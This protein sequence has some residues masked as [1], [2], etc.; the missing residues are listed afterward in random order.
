M[1]HTN[2]NLNFKSFLR[3]MKIVRIAMIAGLLFYL[4]LTIFLIYD[5]PGGFL[6]DAD[7]EFTNILTLVVFAFLVIVIPVGRFIFNSKLKKA[8]EADGLSNKLAAYRSAMIIKWAPVEGV[9]FFA[10]AALLLT[11][12]ALLYVP[13]LI[14]LALLLI[15]RPTRETLIADLQLSAEEVIRL[16]D[17]ELRFG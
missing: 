13:A 16:D 15:F 14:C 12:S 5:L 1:K 6:G 4:V 7:P 17:P 2:Q 3:A 10:V 9:G 11:G 8:S